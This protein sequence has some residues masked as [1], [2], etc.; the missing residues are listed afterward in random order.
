MTSEKEDQI[1]AVGTS[2]FKYHFVPMSQL[3]AIRLEFTN[4]KAVQA[5]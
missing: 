4:R 1:L 3:E 5:A 2:R